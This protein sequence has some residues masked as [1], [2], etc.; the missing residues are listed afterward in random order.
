M[1]GRRALLLPPTNQPDDRR[2]CI[3]ELQ[4]EK[5]PALVYQPPYCEQARRNQEQGKP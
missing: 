5:R 1:Q 4:K 2:S 3:E